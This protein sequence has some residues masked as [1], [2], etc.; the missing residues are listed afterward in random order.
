MGGICIRDYLPRNEVIVMGKA[1]S[2]TNSIQLE[3]V[4]VDAAAV[5]DV[6]NQMLFRWLVYMLW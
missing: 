1:R 2:I 3:S 4:R 5:I 6:A